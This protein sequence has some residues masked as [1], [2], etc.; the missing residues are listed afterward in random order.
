MANPFIT[1]G[2]VTYDLTDTSVN[3]Q[4]KTEHTPV[5]GGFTLK[6][7]INFSAVTAPTVTNKVANTLKILT[8]PKGAIITTARLH[9][10]PGT[11]VLAHKWTDASGSALSSSDGSGATLSMGF[12]WYKSASHS[13]TVAD[14]DA[15]A[16]H[17]ITKKTGL[18]AGVPTFSASTPMT[19][20][21]NIS[22]TSSPTLPFTFPY[23]GYMTWNVTHSTGASASSVYGVF[24]GTVEVRCDC[25]YQET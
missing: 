13:S 14:V 8:V 1:T 17:A 9:D 10:V 16:D 11:T 4:A 24:T 23:G 7:K 2:G 19:N 22:D 3:P 15:L 21:I 5:P 20:Y 18:M 25:Q 12:V 6:N